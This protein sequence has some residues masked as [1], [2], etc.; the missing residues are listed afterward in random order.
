MPLVRRESNAKTGWVVSCITFRNRSNRK[1]H[2]QERMGQIEWHHDYSVGRAVEV[3]NEYGGFKLKPAH[4]SVVPE[5][6]S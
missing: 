2:S 6:T 5:C 3:G 1:P 4:A